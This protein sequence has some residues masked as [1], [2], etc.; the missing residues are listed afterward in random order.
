MQIARPVVA[1]FMYVGV[2]LLGILATEGNVL[3]VGVGLLLFNVVGSFF[4]VYFIKSEEQAPRFAIWYSRGSFFGA[5]IFYIWG[6]YSYRSYMSL[7]ESV[8]VVLFGI[9][10]G[11]L[12]MFLA[13]FMFMLYSNKRFCGQTNDTGV[14]K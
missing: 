13:R 2:A 10:I 4:F 6:V 14:K 11:F 8:F 1:V 9:V 12:V 5:M 3:A 7:S